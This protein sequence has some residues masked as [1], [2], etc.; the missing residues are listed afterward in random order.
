MPC[1]CNSIFLNEICAQTR[2]QK[3]VASCTYNMLSTII[4]RQSTCF[5]CSKKK[6]KVMEGQ[7]HAHL[8]PGSRGESGRR[9][10]GGENEMFLQN[11]IDPRGDVE[12]EDASVRPR[13]GQ[14]E[15]E[16]RHD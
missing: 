12:E 6:I 15:C 5:V 10:T 11:I 4:E 14:K 1:H 16:D 7:A 9:D 13:S 3:L 8:E 2:S